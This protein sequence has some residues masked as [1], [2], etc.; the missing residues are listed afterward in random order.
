MCMMSKPYITNK[1]RGSTISVISSAIL[2][3]S[4]TLV[5]STFLIDLAVQSPSII[6]RKREIE[7]EIKMRNKQVTLLLGVY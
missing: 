4:F 5:T 7:K 1:S 3:T 2:T 6:K